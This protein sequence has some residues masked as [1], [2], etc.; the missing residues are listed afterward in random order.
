VDDIVNI[1]EDKEEFNAEDLIGELKVTTN[2]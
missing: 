2:N 1:S